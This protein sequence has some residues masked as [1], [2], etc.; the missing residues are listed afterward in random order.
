[1]NINTFTKDIYM[2]L[3][4]EPTEVNKRTGIGVKALPGITFQT[5]LEKEGFPLLGLRP[6]PIKMFVAETIFY[7]M[8]TKDPSWLQQYTNIWDKFL[9]ENGE[10]STCYGYRFKEAFGRNQIY[11]LIGLLRKDPTSR[12]GVVS[13]WDPRG[14]G[15]GGE[16]VPN[17]P[18]PISMTVQII[19]GKLCMCVTMRS[20]DAYLGMPSDIAGF[21]LLALILAQVLDVKSGTYTHFIANCHLYTNQIEHAKVLCSRENNMQ[22]PIKV[23]VPRNSY[24]AYTRAVSGDITLVDELVKEIQRQYNPL[25]KMP[26][27]D[28]VI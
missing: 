28:I 22:K 10:I 13:I 6:I 15:L 1:M 20:Q 24:N 21:S 7:L 3:L 9:D 23:K 26:K 19:N 8:G 2:R 16:K 12:H 18:C 25:G 11:E 4:Q 17:L 27:L 5:D 14:D